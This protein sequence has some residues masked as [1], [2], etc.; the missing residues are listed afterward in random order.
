MKKIFLFIFTFIVLA[1][2]NKPR[3]Q[4]ST[5]MLPR[6]SAGIQSNHVPLNTTTANS[7][8]PTTDSSK[9]QSTNCGHY[10]G[11]NFAGGIIF[12]LDASGCHGLIAAATDQTSL[13]R[14]ENGIF[15]LNT[16]AVADGIGAGEGNTKMI[17]YKQ[18]PSGGGV[19]YAAKICND[20]VIG[21]YSDWYLPSK[22][23]L[24]LMFTN[25]GQGAPA[26][27]TNI[28]GFPETW[29]WSSTEADSGRAWRQAFYTGL[30]WQFKTEKFYDHSVRAIRAF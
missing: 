14:W 9:I 25:I 6:L 22:Y 3:K 12:Y 23:E 24:N 18:E 15:V 2:H 5:Q 19:R 20:L 8:K 1:W 7:W 28:G 4:N 16:G 21:T 10:I 26:P 30:G 29:Y 17:I 27:N 11:E 13:A